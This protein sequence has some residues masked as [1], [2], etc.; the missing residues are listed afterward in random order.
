MMEFTYTIKEELGIH[1]RPASLL[2]KTASSLK[3]KVMIKKNDKTADC[4]RILGLMRLGIKCGE[5]VTVSISGEDEEES[6]ETIKEFFEE[7]F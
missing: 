5:T 1:A 7:N 3:S 2:V 4:K 6:F